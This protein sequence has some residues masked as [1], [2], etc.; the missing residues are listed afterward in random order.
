MDRQ[1]NTDVDNT[2]VDSVCYAMPTMLKLTLIEDMIPL[3][4]PFDPEAY[5]TN[6][7]MRALCV[8]LRHRNHGDPS[9]A[10]NWMYG[11]EMEMN[12][13]VPDSAYKCLTEMEREETQLRIVIL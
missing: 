4:K 1:D 8:A 10:L 9:M 7:V 2:D 13:A 12:R 6:S 11:A 5:Y 3:R